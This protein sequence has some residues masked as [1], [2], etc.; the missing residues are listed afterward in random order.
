MDQ[1]DAKNG[2]NV[3]CLISDELLSF[4]FGIAYEV[5]G[6]PR[7]EFGE[8]WYRFSSVAVTPGFIK[9]SGGLSVFVQDGLEALETADLI[10][11]PGWPNLTAPVPQIVI[12]ALRDAHGRGARIASLCSGAAV[13]AAA[14]LLDDRIATTHW[15]FAEELSRTYPE[16]TFD[17]D[18]LYVDDGDVL[19]AAGSA[20]GMDLCIH[21]VRQDYGMEHANII[22]QGL[23]MPTHRDGGESQ[24]IPMPVARPRE[25]S[26]LGH[27][28]DAMRKDPAKDHALSDLAAEVGMSVRTFQRRFEAVTGLAPSAWIAQERLRAACLIL[29]RDDEAPLE[30]IAE[31]CGFGSLATMRHHFRK[32]IGM[33]PSE[34]RA[35]AA[36]GAGPLPHVVAERAL[37]AHPVR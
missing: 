17:P 5:F 37:V 8:H 18:V 35:H 6:L 11:V 27:L 15:R 32:K 34:Y 24:I 20:A 25:S 26:R 7:P 30:D 1:H 4:E 14:G 9:S 10:V 21:I 31:Q 3:V 12:D 36:N 16:I 19:T 29:E 28:I 22:A 13:L 2:P 33:S 23:V